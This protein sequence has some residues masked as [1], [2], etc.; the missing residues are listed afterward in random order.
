MTPTS[1]KAPPTREQ[2]LNSP[3]QHAPPGVTADLVHP[4]SMKSSAEGTIIS[5]YIL[6]TI[7]VLIRVY[8]QR[9]VARRFLLED[10]VVVLT[11][12]RA[13]LNYTCLQNVCLLDP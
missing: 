7:V 10:Y 9:R 11:W 1:A 12:V 8:A 5:L 13:N 3:A 4:W 6:T 2:I